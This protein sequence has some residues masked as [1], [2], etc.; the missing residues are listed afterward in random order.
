ML[1]DNEYGTSTDWY[2][3]ITDHANYTR[4]DTY[5][6]C[7]Q[8]GEINQEYMRDA[9]SEFADGTGYEISIN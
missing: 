3:T 2:R 1:P 9:P 6:W 8:N 4:L 5:I 7:E